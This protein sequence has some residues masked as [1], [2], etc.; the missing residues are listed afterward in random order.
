ML[1]H[2]LYMISTIVNWLLGSSSSICP[3][4]TMI[5][6]DQCGAG[7]ALSWLYAISTILLSNE[8]VRQFR[9]GRVPAADAC[10]HVE[11]ACQWLISG[12][13]DAHHHLCKLYRCIPEPFLCLALTL[14]A[15]PAGLNRAC[16]GDGG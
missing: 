9:A 3:G 15:H 7:W 16:H 12:I 1:G 10:A 5:P 6:E 13:S 14:L 4:T 2:T 8:H 11:S